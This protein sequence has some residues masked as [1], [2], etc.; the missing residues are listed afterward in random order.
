LGK[1]IEHLGISAWALSKIH[2]KIANA[3][4]AYIAGR[5]HEKSRFDKQLSLLG[6]SPIIDGLWSF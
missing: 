3:C 5:D 6:R 4:I 1:N 2:E